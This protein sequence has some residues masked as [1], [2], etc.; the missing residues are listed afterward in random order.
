MAGAIVAGMTTNDD[1]LGW[2][3]GFG[4]GASVVA[5]QQEF[6]G[7]LAAAM[8]ERWLGQLVNCELGR[9]QDGLYWLL[10]I[11]HPTLGVHAVVVRLGDLEPYSRDAL[12]FVLDR[13]TRW[14]W[15]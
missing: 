4:R 2:G 10:T 13:V 11:N 12:E 15:K 6:R 14:V 7:Q 1:A 8:R 3:L 5:K 9:N